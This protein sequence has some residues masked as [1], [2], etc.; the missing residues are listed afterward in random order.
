[1]EKGQMKIAGIVCIVICVIC[2]FVAIERYQA[3]AKNVK[4]MN[5]MMGQVSS[6]FGGEMGII[7]GGGVKP[8]TP[9]ATKY[10]LL[11]A[12]VTGVAGGVLL[13]KSQAIAGVSG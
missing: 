7:G 8:A 9:A 13:V 6:S 3:N 5:S 2:V 1:M 12:V 10:A 11:F 4:A